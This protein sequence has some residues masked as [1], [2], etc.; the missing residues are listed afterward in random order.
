M[1]R[2]SDA[3]QGS[4]NPIGR[5]LDMLSS[6]QFRPFPP[7]PVRQGRDLFYLVSRLSLFPP[8]PNPSQFTLHVFNRLIDN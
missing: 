6:A 1:D 8:S 4:M 7:P 2:K 5:M 3:K